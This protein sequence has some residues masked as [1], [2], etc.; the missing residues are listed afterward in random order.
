MTDDEAARSC[1]EIYNEFW[2][3]WRKKQLQRNSSEW[4][5]V[6]KDVMILLNRH[7]FSLAKHMVLDL[8][9]ELEER[10]RKQEGRA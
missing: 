1:T 3:K 9:D 8:L 7:P 2:L 6:Y 5:Q 10:T 4:E